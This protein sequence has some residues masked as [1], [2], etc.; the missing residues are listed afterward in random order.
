MHHAQPFPGEQESRQRGAHAVELGL[1]AHMV[2]D[3]RVT[4]VHR[5]GQRIEQIAA[6]LIVVEW[7][8]RRDDQL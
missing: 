7:G 1:G 8:Q 6:G 2:G 4:G 5:V 3:R